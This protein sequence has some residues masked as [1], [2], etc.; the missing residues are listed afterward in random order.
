MKNNT[1][2]IINF[3]SGDKLRIKKDGTLDR[4]Y[5]K[6]R[7]IIGKG[8]SNLWEEPVKKPSV[9]RPRKTSIKKKTVK[10]KW[11]KQDKKTVF[12]ATVLCISLIG[13]Q[14]AFKPKKFDASLYRTVNAQELPSVESKIISA[15]VFLENPQTLEEKKDYIKYKFGKNYKVACMVAYG[16][17]LRSNHTNS[18]PVEYS[19]GTFQINLAEDFGRG[20]KVHWDKVPGG[21]LEEK[22]LWLKNPKNNIDLAHKMSNGGE[23]FE[24]W[25]AFSNSSYLKHE[26]KCL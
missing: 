10:N 4:R 2:K 17:G 23:N 3:Y 16:E 12:I 11:T 1:D 5:V 18:S 19:V 7:K 21:T 13:A 22:E 25:G 15:R 9:R 6:A 20:R 14:I 8:T 24:Q 26:E